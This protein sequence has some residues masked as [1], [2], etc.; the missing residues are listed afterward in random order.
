VNSTTEKKHHCVGAVKR[1][2]VV[3][4]K[5]PNKGGTLPPAEGVEERQ[6]TEGNTPKAA[7]SRTLRESFY[8]LRRMAAPGIDGVTWNQD[9]VDL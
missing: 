8:V 5:L 3:P 4:E 7:A 2:R 6:P 9:E 1:G